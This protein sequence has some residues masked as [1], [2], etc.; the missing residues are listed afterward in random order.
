MTPRVAEDGRTCGARQTRARACGFWA[1]MVAM[2]YD[3]TA[4][5]IVVDV[6]NDFAHPAGSL[7]VDEGER[8]I[9][10]INE[11]LARARSAGATVV[12][13]QDW[14][15]EVTPHFAKDG[16]VWPSHCVAETWGAELSP[17]LEVGGEIVRKGIGTDDG[18]SGF[19][20][21]DLTTG[22]RDQTSLETILR[23]NGVTRVAVTGLATD[24]CVRATALDASGRG[25]DVTVLKDGI[26]AVNLKPDDGD[27]AVK[28]MREAGVRFE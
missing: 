8:V 6:Q 10:L 21:C 24:Y 13:T 2:D 16:G 25:F 15:P 7:Y 9:P 4:A 11:E 23:D 28:E 14:H 20:E 27:N 18:Y 3:A 1:I 26:R 17:D 12:F 5:L 22:N 19:S